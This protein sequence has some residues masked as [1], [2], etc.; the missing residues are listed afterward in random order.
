MHNEAN[1]DCTVDNLLFRMATCFSC[2]ITGVSLRE[3]ENIR[4][5]DSVADNANDDME[6][7]LLIHFIEYYLPI[8]DDAFSYL[9]KAIDEDGNTWL[10]YALFN[11]NK[12]FIELIQLVV[13]SHEFDILSSSL[14]NMQL[15][16]IDLLLLKIEYRSK[17]LP[18]EF[19]VNDVDQVFGVSYG[20]FLN[21]AAGLHNSC[22]LFDHCVID[23]NRSDESNLIDLF[24][25]NSNRLALE[26]LMIGL[27]DRI[28]AITVENSDGTNANSNVPDEDNSARDKYLADLFAE[29]D[30]F[31]EDDS[32]NST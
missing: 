22:Q 12:R 5:V 20:S 3:S 10:H 17:N 19:V 6:E 30:E 23:A 18:I 11:G 28:P 14:N 15:T 25:K 1:I 29:F 27:K 13:K 9:Q 8:A 7:L 31:V 21:G 4:A 24:S 2:L 16:P 32:T 26:Q